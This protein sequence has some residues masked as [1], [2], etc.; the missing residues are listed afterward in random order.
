MSFIYSM[1]CLL[2]HFKNDLHALHAFAPGFEMGVKK[3]YRIVL[4]ALLSTYVEV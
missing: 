3:G 4:R 1:F 2:N